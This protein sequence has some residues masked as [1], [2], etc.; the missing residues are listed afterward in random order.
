M[1]SLSLQCPANLLRGD[2]AG[3]NQRNQLRNQPPGP[4][5]EGRAP[6]PAPGPSTCLH[7]QQCACLWMP[8]LP[9]LMGHPLGRPSDALRMEWT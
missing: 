3:L 2:R 5:K 1:L 8:V 7:K 9:D 4:R 6:S